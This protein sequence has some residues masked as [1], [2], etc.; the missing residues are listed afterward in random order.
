[1]SKWAELVKYLNTTNANPESVLKLIKNTWKPKGSGKTYRIDD[2]NTLRRAWK[3]HVVYSIHT[4][5]EKQFDQKIWKFILSPSYKV[6]YA[7]MHVG[8]KTKTEDQH[9]N[10]CK[11]LYYTSKDIRDS[12][13]K[14]KG[15]PSPT[16]IAEI[17][18]NEAL[19]YSAFLE[20]GKKKNQQL[21]KKIFNKKKIDT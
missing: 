3:Y 6:A 16:E 4:S 8:E 19:L 12:L 13:D 7:S 14:R 17:Q 21:N 18:D 2:Y 15:E 11:K 1:M 20:K 5:K 9:F 10:A